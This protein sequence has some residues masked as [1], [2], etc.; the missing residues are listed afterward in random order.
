MVL[1]AELDDGGALPDGPLPQASQGDQSTQPPLQA[2]DEEAQLAA[3]RAEVAALKLSASESQEVGESQGD[4]PTQPIA[5]QPQCGVYVLELAG[6][7]FYV[8][9]E[10]DM[11]RR[12][13]KHKAKKCAPR[14]ARNGCAGPSPC[15]AS[16]R[17]TVDA[18]ARICRHRQHVRGASA[19]L[20]QGGAR[21][22]ARLRT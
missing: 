22:V 3:L 2:E 21:C 7:K 14:A 18:A 15:V 10:R 11:V 13:E 6:G 20:V 9:S 5:T 12:I 1:G 4:P 16:Q 19:P 8:G 17:R